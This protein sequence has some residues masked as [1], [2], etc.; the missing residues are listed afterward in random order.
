M[1]SLRILTMIMLALL[2]VATIVTLLMGGFMPLFSIASGLVF[3]YYLVVL[4]GIKLAGD[5]PR[6]PYIYILYAL[7]L[8]PILLTLFDPEALIDFLLQGV[9]LDMR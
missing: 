2:A 4:L 9:H 8:I 3:L 1:K 6:L 5:R 7:F